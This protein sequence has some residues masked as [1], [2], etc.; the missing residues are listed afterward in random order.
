MTTEPS[1]P[2]SVGDWLIDTR[3]PGQPGQFTGKTSLAGSFTMVELAFPD[4][5]TTLRPSHV[6]KPLSKQP[7][8]VKDRL[9]AGDFGRASDLKRVI[10]YE[11]LKGTVHEV[12]YSM[13]AAQIDFYPYQFK[14][15]MKII[16]APTERLILADEVGLG[17]TIESALIWLEL[18]ARRQAKR[19][20]VVCPKTLA[21]KW[22]EEL[23]QKFLIDARI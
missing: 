20:L 9:L 17:K 5:S 23:R 18:Q 16:N 11:K 15:V 6:L 1:L 12:I 10:T 2:F 14:P 22:R 4:G 3:N 7:P 13:E 19:L 21:E 8:T